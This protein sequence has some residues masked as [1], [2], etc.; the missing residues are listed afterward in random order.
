MSARIAETLREHRHCLLV[1]SALTALMTFPTIVYVFRTD[2]FWLPTGSGHDIYIKFWDSWYTKQILTNQADPFF[3]ELLNYPHGLSLVYHPNFFLHG[4]ALNML[5]G[6]LPLANAYSLTYLLIAVSSA[7]AAY[8]YLRYLFRE[9]WVA[10]FGAAIIGAHPQS[11][12]LPT[13][14]EIS[15][16]APLLLLM[17]WLHRGLRERRK[18]MVALAGALTGFTS[19][20]TPYQYVC[21]LILLGLVLCA[22]T[23]REWRDRRFWQCAA[24]LIA[25]ALLSSAWRVLPMLESQTAIEASLLSHEKDDDYVDILSFLVNAG[26]PTNKSL[27]YSLLQIP[28]HASIPHNTYLGML[29]LALIAL[30]LSDSGLRCRMLP[31]LALGAVFLILTLGSALYINGSKLEAIPMPKA[32]LNNLLPSVFLAFNR[33]S[34]FM[35]GALLPLAVLSCFGLLALRKKFALAAHPGI[36]IVLIFL[37]ALEYHVPVREA[38]FD[39]A[40]YSSVAWLAEEDESHVSIINLPMERKNRKYFLYYQT[41]GAFPQIQGAIR[42]LPASAFDYTR[43]NEILHAWHELQPVTCEAANR[44]MYL[45]ALAQLEVDGFSHIVFHRRLRNAADIEPSFRNATAS[46]SDAFVSIY[47][48]QDLRESCPT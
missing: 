16:I 25:A 9:R 32:I 29:P 21:A 14:P 45:S 44:G 19:T 1:V 38:E 24:V 17:Y 33:S 43:T 27:M 23:Y 39:V 35:M 5:Q 42:R 48:L 3:T 30:G 12:A 28:D 41:L 46:Y 22:F 36:I 40:Q 37:V 34:L 6:L 13:W 20:V 15:W 47:R 10:V 31:W 26:S 2:A 7:W 4:I 11:L 18:G 8:I